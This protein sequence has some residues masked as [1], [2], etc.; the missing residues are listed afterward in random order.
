M[1]ALATYLMFATCL[2]ADGSSAPSP[3]AG[4]YLEIRAAEEVP[5]V[6]AAASD[7]AKA[8]RA[9]L[10]WQVERGAFQGV[11][12]AGR[13]ILAVVTDGPKEASSLSRRE[14]LFIVDDGA[15]PAQQAALVELA[16]ALAPESIHNSRPV[17]TRKLDA[18]FGCGC[19]RGY[20]IV[21]C[22]LVKIRTRRPADTEVPAPPAGSQPPAPLGQV[23]YS[24]PAAAEECS[25]TGPLR[26]VLPEQTRSL[27]GGFSL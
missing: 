25:C 1:T 15:S 16:K 17:V 8:V 26:F 18:R 2:A 6:S 22:D 24:Y 4:V 21:E 11:E 9:I 5:V 19:A 13:T 3:A 12:L 20:A 23:F 7:E 14:T 27:T 10:V